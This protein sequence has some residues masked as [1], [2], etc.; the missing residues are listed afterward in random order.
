MDQAE[1]LAWGVRIYG[2]TALALSI[3]LLTA[4]TVL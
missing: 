2:C 3:K 4:I 1:E